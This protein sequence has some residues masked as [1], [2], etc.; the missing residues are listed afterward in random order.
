MK[1][2]LGKNLSLR[3]ERYRIML[4]LDKASCEQSRGRAEDRKFLNETMPIGIFLM[5]R[6][7]E[8][9]FPPWSFPWSAP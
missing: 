8:S 3:L 6:N 7:I 9:A 1:L 2:D 5:H 4:R